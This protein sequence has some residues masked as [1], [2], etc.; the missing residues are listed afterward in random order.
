ML[1]NFLIIG[2]AKAGT[3]SLYHYLSVHPQVFMAHPKELKFFVEEMNWSR[4]LPW[5]ERQ[6]DRAGSAIAIGEAST[7]YTAY[8]YFRGVPERIAEVMPE[9]RLIYLVR[10]PVDRMI[11]FY[12]MRIRAGKER[13]RSMEKALLTNPRYVDGSRYAMQ[14]EQY[15]TY[16][17]PERL[18]VIKSEDLRDARLPTMDRVLQ[19]LEVGHIWVPP[20]IDAEY[21]AARSKGARA[22]RPAAR[23][24]VEGLRRM[25]GSKAIGSVASPRLKKRIGRS[26]KHRLVTTRL[27]PS[28][29]I[30]DTARHE[31]EERLRPDVQRL[32][33][34]IGDDFDGWG[35]G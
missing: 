21:N 5:Y 16:F 29:V 19:F 20:N 4:G 10:H 22:V 14:I 25:P 3:T 7:H 28:A 27:N 35:I 15:L 12:L 11:S 9:V 13:Q 23:A 1:P 18:L 33:G 2:A 31:L 24:I 34:Y 17:P 26:V 32:R 30:S 6:F 8:P